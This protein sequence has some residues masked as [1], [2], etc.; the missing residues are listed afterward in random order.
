MH[1]SFFETSR[2]TRRLLRAALS[3]CLF[4]ALAPANAATPSKCREALSLPLEHSIAG[5]APAWKS[6][7]YAV[8]VM[9]A[10]FLVIEANGIEAEPMPLKIRFLGKDCRS[11]ASNLAV[12][13]IRGRHIH[14]VESGTY[15]VE[16]ASGSH[17]G[18]GYRLDAWLIDKPSH[19]EPMDESD[20]ITRCDPPTREPMDESD[21]I[22]QCDPPTREPMD[23]SDEFTQ[24]APPTREPMDESDEITRCDPPTREPMDESDEITRCDPPTREPMDESDEITRCDP[25]TREPMDESDEFTGGGSVWQEIAGHGLLE[26]TRSPRGL[27][28][29][30]HS[31]CPWIRRHD[32]LA[33]YTCAPRLRLAVSGMLTVTAPAGVGSRLIGVTLA[34][35]GRLAIEAVDNPSATTVVFDARGRRAGELNDDAVWLEAGDYFL[36]TAADGPIRIYAQLD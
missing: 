2:M 5:H 26:I 33:T 18:V 20:E 13:A 31:L 14:Q 29:R 30:F 6:E 4:T 35:N 12:Q 1:A 23:E 24:C 15:Y 16:I 8:D 17:R 22:A 19:R 3:I 32:L 27:E 11:T 25:P 28:T 21:E 36:E 9:E 10:G 7:L 34:S